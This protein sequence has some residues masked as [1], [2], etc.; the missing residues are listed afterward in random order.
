MANWAVV[1]LSQFEVATTFFPEG[2]ATWNAVQQM[3]NALRVGMKGMEALKER[4]KGEE[5][6][7]TVCYKDGE[8]ALWE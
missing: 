1:L 8:R 2:F 5:V 6:E 7:G 3:D 4:G